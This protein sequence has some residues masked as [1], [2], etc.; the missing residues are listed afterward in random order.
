MNLE[1][2]DAYFRGVLSM[3]DLAS[4]DSSNNGIQIGCGD[5]TIERI[6]FAVDAS[7]ESARRAASWKADMLFVHHGLL[8]SRAVPL[9]GF[10]L[11]RVREF[12]VN[13]MALYV[14]HLPLDMHAEVG[15]NGAMAAALD[16]E[17]RRPFG[18]YKG[19]RI[20]QR[21]EL[22]KPA[23]LDQVIIRLFG[24][25][26]AVLGVLPFGPEE[27]RTVGIV[28]GGAPYDVR[29]AIDEDLDLYIT[30]DASHNVYHD[31][32][33]AGINVIF[34]GHYATETW[35]VK[36]LAGRCAADTGI[37][38]TFLDIPTGL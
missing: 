23:T 31:C 34:G 12:M 38:T 2:A 32:L 19:Q 18:E 25:G 26:D 13:D 1:E 15:N 37:K 4:I 6:A 27:I 17:D 28:S 29:Q 16:L 22:P 7:L 8:W 33:E 10:H 24:S 20:G 5:K 9:V 35:G 3:D 14:A 30:G 21:G 36:T 11:E